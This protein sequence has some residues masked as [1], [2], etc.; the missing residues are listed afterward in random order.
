MQSIDRMHPGFFPTRRAGFLAGMAGAALLGAA[1]LGAQQTPAGSTPA[2][3]AS[4]PV[5]TGSSQATTDAQGKP[6]ETVSLTVN[7]GKKK[8]PVKTERVQQTK[9]TRAEIRKE[10]KFNPLV[11]KD[12]ALP[13]KQL[14]D[15]AMTQ[16][17]RGHYDVGRLDLQTLLNTYP[18]SQY[19]MRSKLA[20]ADAWYRE[21]GSAALAQAEQEYTDFITFFPNAPEAGEAQ[22]RVGDIYFKQIDA[23]DRDY[24]KVL[25]AQEAYRLMLKTYPDAPPTLLKQ[26]KQDLREVQELLAERESQLGTFYAGHL[27]WAAAIARFQTVVDTYPQ[28]S[29]LDDVL[30]GIGD[31][32]GSQAR[33][34][35]TQ[36]TCGAVAKNVPCLP[37][38]VKAKLLDSYESKAA[39]QYRK[40]VL[41]H[42]AAPHVEDARERLV[43]MGQTPPT[44]TPE[45]V[46]AS[47]VLEGSRAQYTM[48]KRL[49]LIF[50]RRPDTVVTARTGEPPLEDPA[51]TLAPSVLDASKKEYMAAVT[52]GGA[53]RATP[54]VPAADAA[55]TAPADQPAE[56]SAAA[57]SAPLALQS[58]AGPGEG[59]AAG[60]TATMTNA[61]G[62]SG[63]GNGA[64]VGM[65]IVA[66]V[67]NRASDVPAASGAPDANFGLKTTGAPNAALPA[68]EGPVA[69]SDQVNGAVGLNQ[70]AAAAVDPNAKKKPKPA[71]DKYD[72]SSSKNK[73]KKGVKKLNPF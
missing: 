59:T 9:D 65:S 57:A 12:L 72:E 29:H 18:D 53:I 48:S 26:A 6:S 23:T 5:L 16:I 17:Q 67:S 68:P 4:A 52:P 35:R 42:A 2:Q 43:D 3:P 22:M 50:L 61:A 14:Y 45:Q 11:G 49:Q 70:P 10:K 38:A 71:F 13:D 24:S 8:K 56:P 33:T 21:G 37:E 32:Y 63:G 31:A 46:A 73:P 36:P 69:A 30:I 27:N 41:E 15:K 25:K 47:E 28:Y 40:V 44:P 55:D 58:V 64:S 60:D 62:A 39:A 34:L 66:P 54:A 19:M 7:T 51:P 1:A 20:V